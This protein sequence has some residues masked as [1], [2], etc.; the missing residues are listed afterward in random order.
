[1]T[2]NNLI[3]EELQNI[4]LESVKDA[5]FRLKACEDLLSSYHSNKSIIFIE[6]A[7]LQLRK[8]LELIA[9]AAIAPNKYEYEKFRNKAESH[10]D[11]RKDFKAS[12]ILKA[13]RKVNKD[14]YPIPLTEAKLTETGDYHYDR[15]KE[16]FL[17]VS[18]FITLYDKL[19]KYL[20]AD[21][22]WGS[23]KEL[24]N[25]AQSMVG[26]INLIKSLLSLY[27]TVIRTKD[28]TGVWILS[29]STEHV[30]VK[31]IVGLADGNFTVTS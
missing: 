26:E 30:S 15:K 22:P 17:T 12:S 28:F 9:F 1:M 4:Y 21:N 20:H 6:S 14:F 24:E 23:N 31:I 8:A 3:M 25:F 13:L 10:N 16:N 18:K 27:F 29:T 5:L 11:Y 2:H 7:I 19:G